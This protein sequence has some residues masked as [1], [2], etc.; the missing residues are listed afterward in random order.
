MNAAECY[1][2]VCRIAHMY[3]LECVQRVVVLNAYSSPSLP[4]LLISS[5]SL[6]LSL[7]LPPILFTFTPSLQG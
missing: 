5:I 7:S 4:L 3:V 1:D 6:S 2:K